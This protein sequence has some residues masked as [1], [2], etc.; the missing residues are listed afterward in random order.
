MLGHGHAASFNSAQPGRSIARFSGL[1]RHCLASMDVIAARPSIRAHRS[2]K[3][4]SAQPSDEAELSGW[5]GSLVAFL[6][7]ADRVRWNAQSTTPPY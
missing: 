5:A 4:I 6:L 7:Y 3:L 2:V 1:P